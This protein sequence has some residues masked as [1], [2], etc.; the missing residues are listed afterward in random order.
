MEKLKSP[1]PSLPQ[2]EGAGKLIINQKNKTNE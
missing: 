1:T 2:G